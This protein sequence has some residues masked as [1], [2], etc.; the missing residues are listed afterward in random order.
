MPQK[1]VKTNELCCVRGK[2]NAAQHSSNPQPVVMISQAL[3]EK[4]VTPFSLP[5]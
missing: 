1:I 3:A 4:N 5:C 2:L